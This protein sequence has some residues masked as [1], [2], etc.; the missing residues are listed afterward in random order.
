M[1]SLDGRHHPGVEL[2]SALTEHAL[3]RHLVRE[4]VLECVLRVRKQA[5]S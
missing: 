4:C 3:V 5:V 1:Q 2:P